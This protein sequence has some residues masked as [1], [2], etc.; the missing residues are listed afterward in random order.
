MHRKGFRNSEIP[1][2]RKPEK[3]WFFR[4]AE[5]LSTKYLKLVVT[6]SEHVQMRTNTQ[7]V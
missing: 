6:E 5:L 2:M 3:L 7:G 1:D 4:P